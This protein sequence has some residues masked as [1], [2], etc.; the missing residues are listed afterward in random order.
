ME[1]DDALLGDAQEPDELQITLVQ[2]DL[3]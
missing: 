1:G 2:M 3:R